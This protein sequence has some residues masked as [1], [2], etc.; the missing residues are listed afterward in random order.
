MSLPNSILAI[1]RVVLAPLTA[2]HALL[3]ARDLRSAFDWK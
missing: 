1:T 3:S 2:I